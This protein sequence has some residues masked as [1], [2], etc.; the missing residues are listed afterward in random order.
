[1]DSNSNVT[2]A[3]P[4]KSGIDPLGSGWKTE[5]EKISLLK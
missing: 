2:V 1:M 4:A 3:Y 5:H